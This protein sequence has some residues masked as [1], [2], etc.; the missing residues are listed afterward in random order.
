[1]TLDEIADETLPK[2]PR[3]CG[4]DGCH[5]LRHLLLV[6]FA[7]NDMEPDRTGELAKC[8]LRRLKSEGYLPGWL[9]AEYREET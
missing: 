4:C 8:L 9:A 5:R 7:W 3:C 2:H 1:M 6:L